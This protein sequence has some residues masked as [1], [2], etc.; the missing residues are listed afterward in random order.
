M[1][2][3]RRWG[4]KEWGVRHAGMQVA[5]KAGGM[6]EGVLV[7]RRWGSREWSVRGWWRG[8]HVQGRWHA[9][10]GAGGS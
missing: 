7:A 8:R 4:S 3:A 10:G 1:L 9:G 6:Q 5:C 2:V